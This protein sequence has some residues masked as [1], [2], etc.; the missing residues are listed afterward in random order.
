MITI[1]LTE[2]T[3]EFCN[4]HVQ[5]SDGVIRA[6]PL[7][8]NDAARLSNDVRRLNPAPSPHEWEEC[9]PQIAREDN[10]RMAAMAAV[11]PHNG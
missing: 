2:G 6:Y 7:T 4:L 10:H 9:H 1:W 5:D 3:T 11:D 8:H